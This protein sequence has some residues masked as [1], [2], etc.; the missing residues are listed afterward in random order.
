MMNMNMN[1]VSNKLLERFFRK[2]DNVV[3]DLFTG[4]IGVRTEDGITT[5]EGKGEDAQITVNMFD[6]FGMVVP[7]FAQSTPLSAVAVGDL[8]FGDKKPMGWVVEVKD[9]KPSDP[10]DAAAHVGV[11]KFVLMTPDGTRKTWVPPKVSM[12]GFESGVMV[13]RSL[14]SMLPGGSGSLGAMQNMLMP[15]MMMG[16][17][18][19]DLDSIMPMMLFS[20]LGGASGAAGGAADPAAMGGMGNMMQMMMMM[21]MMKGGGG[22]LFGSG[23]KSSNGGNA[24]VDHFNRPR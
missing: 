9:S 3:W 24:I 12:L 17:G 11:K 1:N 13:L 15:M 22:N 18:D 23:N 19:L 20:Q 14:M 21:Q 10:A 5:I 8:I 2:V 4:R 6:Q 7:A 16:G